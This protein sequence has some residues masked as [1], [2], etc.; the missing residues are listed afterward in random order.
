MNDNKRISCN[1]V[2]YQ[3]KQFCKYFFKSL[4][5]IIITSAL[6][7]GLLWQCGELSTIPIAE[8]DIH[9]SEPGDEKLNK[10]LA[11]GE[12]EVQEYFC[13][14]EKE[15]KVFL[16]E[17]KSQNKRLIGIIPVEKNKSYFIFEKGCCNVNEKVDIINIVSVNT[18]KKLMNRNPGSITIGT[19]KVNNGY[20]IILRDL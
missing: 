4:A 14:N 16:F 8:P 10:D 3:S 7:G 2:G 6:I 1:E 19:H 13:V 9:T 11:E 18:I 12:T 17:K 20:L 15:L 5:R